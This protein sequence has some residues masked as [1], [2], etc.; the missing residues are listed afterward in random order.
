MVVAPSSRNSCRTSSADPVYDLPGG[1][2]VGEKA[3]VGGHVGVGG[4]PAQAAV[5]LDEEAAG[6]GFHR[7]DSRGDSRSASS[8]LST[9]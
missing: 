6:A 2:A 3:A 9:S 5:A 4:L 8:N 7:A 1:V